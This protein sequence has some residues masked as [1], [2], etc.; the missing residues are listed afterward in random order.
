ME[1]PTDTITIRL[2]KN[3][4][5]ELK[6]IAETKNIS[7]N[8]LFVQ[9]LRHHLEVDTHYDKFDWV[10]IPKDMFIQK[11]KKLTTPEIIIM[12][13]KL[14]DEFAVDFI[15]TK[16]RK[17]SNDTVLKFIKLFI[18]ENS[19]G[20]CKISDHEKGTIISI[21]HTMGKK[22]SK[23]FSVLI[24]NLF[25]DQLNKETSSDITNNFVLIK[26]PHNKHYKIQ[27][28]TPSDIKYTW[29]KS[30]FKKN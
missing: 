2:K 4:I 29:Y 23:L 8:T 7:L 19:L 18:K 27:T 25:L 13:K 9:L 20:H 10:K 1:S 17:I 14:S 11:M 28:K 5:N 15:L 6:A 21:H 26:I 3:Q 22:S 12:G 30:S 24:Q 16:W